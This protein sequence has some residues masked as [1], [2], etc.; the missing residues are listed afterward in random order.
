M[1]ARRPRK[2]A[3]PTAV[4]TAPSSTPSFGVAAFNDSPL[5][6]SLRKQT[7]ARK[8]AGIGHDL[9]DPDD[10]IMHILQ[11][12][13]MKNVTPGDTKD[14]KMTSRSDRREII[15]KVLDVMQSMGLTAK[16]AS[17]RN[18]AANLRTIRDAP[19]GS[20][21]IKKIYLWVEQNYTYKD[22]QSGEESDYQ[23]ATSDVEARFRFK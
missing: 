16:F 10:M 1:S 6:Q 5:V 23:S 18:L 20:E 9:T 2:T 3:T 21:A 4:L 14:K 8:Q 7:L 11:A 15:Q 19:G 12:A 17:E 22:S 13:S